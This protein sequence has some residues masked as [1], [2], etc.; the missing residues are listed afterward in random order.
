MDKFYSQNNKGNYYLGLVSSVSRKNATIQI[1]NF[2]L[3]QSRLISN[4]SLIPSSIDYTVV[5]E[6]GEGLFMGTVY[7]T[8]VKNT[9]NVHK[10]LD[11][12]EKEKVLPSV[13]INV[14]AFKPL[15]KNDFSLPGFKTVGVGDKVYIANENILKE[16]LNSL[17]INEE[18]NFSHFDNET[19]LL[20]DIGSFS[21]LDSVNFSIEPDTLMNRHL[22]VI[23]AT[24]SGK[25]TSAL[26]ILERLLKNRNK[27][28]IIDPTGEY[29][30]SFN[31]DE[32]KKITLGENATI[33]PGKLNMLQWSMLFELNENTQPATLFE[34]IQALRYQHKN[35]LD[36]VYIKQGKKV[37]AVQSDLDKLTDEEQGFDMRLLTEQIKENSCEINK[38]DE[39]Y[40]KSFVFNT[41]QFLIRKIDYVLSE[42]SLLSFFND[43]TNHDLILYLNNFLNED[44]R[45]YIDTS[46]IGIHD[47][48]GGMIV[49]LVTNHLLN[50]ANKNKPFV[51]FLDEA[52]RYTRN[53]VT[54]N[55]EFYTGITS[56]A[57]E[58]RKKG[59]YLLLTTQ[60]PTD[61]SNILLAQMGS[62]L[63]HR[64]NHQKELDTI[65]NFIDRDLLP[66]VNKLSQGEAILSSV[67]LLQNIVLKMK[68][69]S[70][71][72]DNQ[73]PIL[74]KMK[75]DI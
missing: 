28:L 11:R 65:S 16:Y 3:L 32:V 34:A 9:D 64:L 56:I 47:G 18:R 68:K 69:A 38:Q 51:F 25:S 59:Q 63:V 61:V 35:S 19:N 74:Y 23:G 67:N 73:S 50:N 54:G 52:H 27:F 45:L 66:T 5:I 1:E 49:D 21:N 8:G 17:H 7:Y 15:Y 72:H 2:S 46:K 4:D 36:G 57:R 22:M 70:R 71:K 58:G 20:K 39:Y 55:N 24:G 14:I 42:S 12:G 44:S 37:Y 48:V 53:N 30:D 6:S 41:N 60:S 10:A 43:D 33:S 29:K 40:F 26:N 62:L 75:S 13:F 31:E